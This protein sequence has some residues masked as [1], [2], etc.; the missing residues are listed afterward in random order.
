MLTSSKYIK[1]IKDNF[2]IL[3]M[4]FNKNKIVYAGFHH[5]IKVFDVTNDSIIHIY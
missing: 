3:T 2:P 5:E 4:D 1:E